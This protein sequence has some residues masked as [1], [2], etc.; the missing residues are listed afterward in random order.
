MIRFWKVVIRRRALYFSELAKSKVPENPL[1]WAQ[2]HQKSSWWS[3]SFI[4]SILMKKLL[5]L[6]HPYLVQ[7]LRGS[8]IHWSSCGFHITGWIQKSSNARKLFSMYSHVFFM[9]FRSFYIPNPCA[10]SGGAGEIFVKKIVC[11]F[12]PIPLFKVEKLGP[13]TKCTKI[14]T[15]YMAHNSVKWEEVFF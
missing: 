1:T 15:L 2:P 9:Y 12:W 13:L 6:T 8:L 5:T 3:K 10:S 14:S 4:I 11:W 7:E